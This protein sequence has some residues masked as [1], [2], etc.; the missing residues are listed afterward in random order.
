MKTE[1]SEGDAKRIA[2]IELSDKVA[3]SP[4]KLAKVRLFPTNEAT[5]ATVTVVT[6]A[7]PRDVPRCAMVTRRLT[8]S[9]SR[10]CVQEMGQV[11]QFTCEFSNVH[12]LI[13]AAARATIKYPHRAVERCHTYEIFKKHQYRCT[14]CN[15]QFGRHSNSVDVETQR[16]GLV[17]C[18]S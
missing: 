15:Y 11:V 3:D 18:R 17:S 9:G 2:R 6:D 13:I 7:A 8:S 1:K 12:D 14:S 5:S 10:C 4:F 16:C